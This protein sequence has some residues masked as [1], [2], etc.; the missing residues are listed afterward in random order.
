VAAALIFI[1]EALAKQQP[2]Q[3]H[4]MGILPNYLW[5]PYPEQLQRMIYDLCLKNM[6][7]SL[8]SL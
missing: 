5:D 8:K 7:M 3:I 6:E 1:T 2:L 4:Q